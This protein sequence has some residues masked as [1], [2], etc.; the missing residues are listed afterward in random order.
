MTYTEPAL[1][2]NANIISWDM[3]RLVYPVKAPAVGLRPACACA[4]VCFHP[5]SHPYCQV[6][7]DLEPARQ[8]TDLFNIKFN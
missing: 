5:Y 4:H 7:S 8:G 2:I 3:A 1:N 6:W